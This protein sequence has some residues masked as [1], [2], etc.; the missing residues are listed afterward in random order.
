MRSGFNNPIVT[1]IEVSGAEVIEIAVISINHLVIFTGP[2]GDWSIR[3][4]MNPPGIWDI[5]E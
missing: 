2:A 1:V 5:Y 3:S 4:Q